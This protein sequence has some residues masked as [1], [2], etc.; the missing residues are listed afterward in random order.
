M[1]TLKEVTNQLYNNSGITICIGNKAN[2]Y[3]SLNKNED[4]T[5]I[6]NIQRQKISKA[7]KESHELK[8]HINKIITAN[9]AKIGFFKLTKITTNQTKSMGK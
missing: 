2:I 5:K 7:H 4:N 1:T 6:E 9:N 3:I 8:K